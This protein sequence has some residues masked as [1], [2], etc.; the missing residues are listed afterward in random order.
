M[1]NYFQ[2]PP[3]TAYYVMEFR[4]HAKILK[5]GSLSDPSR[6]LTGRERSWL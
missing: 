2:T 6:K 4:K 1:L 5:S 3:E